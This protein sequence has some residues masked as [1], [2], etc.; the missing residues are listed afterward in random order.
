MRQWR[1]ASKLTFIFGLHFD[2]RLFIDFHGK[3]S[4]NVAKV[5]QLNTGVLK[6]SLSLLKLVVGKFELPKEIAYTFGLPSAS[7]Q[8]TQSV[9]REDDF[10][11]VLLLVEVECLKYKTL[12]I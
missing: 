12:L 9:Y 1:K 6:T 5:W 2:L 10:W 11:K 4:S 7:E 3:F 8:M